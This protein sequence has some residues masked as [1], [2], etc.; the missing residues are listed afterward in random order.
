[1]VRSSPLAGAEM[2]TF[3][4]P[5]ER[6]LAASSRL[7]KRPVDSRT[8]STSRPSRKVRGILFFQDLE[9]LLAGDDGVSLGAHVLLEVPEDR[10]VL[11]QMRQRPGVGHVVRG[12]DVDL[13]VVN[14]RAK[15]VSSDASESVDPNLD[16]HRGPLSRKAE[17][18]ERGPAPEYRLPSS[19]ASRQPKL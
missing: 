3:L 4:A 5:A 1:M 15:H 18:R 14:R 2:M 6:C 10:V 9:A 11:E 12:D 19:G 16:S 13:R 7:V 8:I 17:T